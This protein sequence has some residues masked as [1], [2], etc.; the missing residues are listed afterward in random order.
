MRQIEQVIGNSG[1]KPPSRRHIMLLADIMTCQGHS[2]VSI[3]RNGIKRSDIGPLARCSFE[4]TD[5]QLYQ[6]AIFGEHDDV[7]G[8]SANIML[9]QVPPC[10]TG[11]IQVVFDEVEF[12]RIQATFKGA[13]GESWEKHVRQWERDLEGMDR[14]Q[15]AMDEL[16]GDAL[17]TFSDEEDEEAVTYDTQMEFDYTEDMLEME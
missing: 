2:L 5:K 4:E 6:A 17:P 11:M 8:V 1:T 10:G 9:G 16:E 7:D 3:D 12:E 15:A 14:V 13:K